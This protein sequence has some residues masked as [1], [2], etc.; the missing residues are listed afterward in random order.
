MTT[1]QI[2]TLHKNQ[3]AIPSGRQ[4][5]NGK[6]YMADA[7]G[8]L[9]PV[10][11]IAPQDLLEDEVVRRVMSFSKPLSEQIGR[12]KGHVFNDLSEF[13][14]LLEQQYGA[15]KGGAKGNKTYM[16][17]D[18]LLKVTISVADNIDFGP[19]LQVAKSLID[20]CLNEWAAE[21]GPEIRAVVTKAFN[22][23]KEG[24]INKSEIFTLL[25]LEI[26]DERWKRAMQAIRD[27]M[28][29]VGTK[30]YQRY[31]ER[32]SFDA[33]WEAITIDI[34]KAKLADLER[35]ATLGVA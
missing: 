26:N 1:E 10:E 30:T 35:A 14:A 22:T 29:I 5:I 11:L 25:R 3:I 6:D 13:D 24:L 27:A 23:D 34:A 2:N 9:T 19:E 33:P 4:T 31:Y 15:K 32:P 12:F 7:K 18:G 20:E 17:Y 16:T 8:N 28:R 21:S